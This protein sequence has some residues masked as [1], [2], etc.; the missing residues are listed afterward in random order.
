MFDFSKMIDATRI[1]DLKT[2][3][4]KEALREMVDVL[5]TSPCVGDR[6]ELFEAI[7]ERELL[8][9]T[10]V[11]LS[12]ALPHVKIASV[13]DFVIAIGRSQRGIDYDAHDGQ[14]VHLIVMIGANDK[15]SGEYL[16][17]LANLVL[18]IKEK[19]FRKQVLFAPDAKRIAELFC[20]T[21]EQ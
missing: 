4:K 13:S 11:G 5:A 18:K 19:D 6:D 14:P 1:V 16:K 17:V 12:A 9:S 8:N 20:E 10:G 3:D 2:T 7:L 15:Q 21:S